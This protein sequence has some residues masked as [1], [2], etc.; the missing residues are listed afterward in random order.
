MK[1]PIQE[2]EERYGK[3]KPSV[4]LPQIFTDIQNLLKLVKRY[5]DEISAT[6][7]TG[8]FES[9]LKPIILEETFNAQPTEQK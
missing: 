9:E 2:I 4:G 7:P 1:D 3:G 5:E 6:T 8:Y